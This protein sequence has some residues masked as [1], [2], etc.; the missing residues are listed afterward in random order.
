MSGRF[1]I[2]SVLNPRH[3]HFFKHYRI[4]PNAFLP[5]QVSAILKTAL[6]ASATLRTDTSD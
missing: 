3:D 6:N 2:Q 4:R 5:P 1:H